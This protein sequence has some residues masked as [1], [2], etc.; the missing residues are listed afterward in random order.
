MYNNKSDKYALL[1]FTTELSLSGSCIH[2][3][4]KLMFPSGYAH[5]FSISAV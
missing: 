5:Q 2:T 4:N 3:V 1:S